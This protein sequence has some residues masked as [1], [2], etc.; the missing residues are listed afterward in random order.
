M[1]LFNEC[2]KTVESCLTD[3]NMDKSN[4]ADVVLVGGSSRIPKVQQLLQEFFQAEGVVQE[5]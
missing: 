3:A 5:H 4:V 1:D 2:M